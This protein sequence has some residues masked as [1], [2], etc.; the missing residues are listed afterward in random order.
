MAR[1]LKI[2]RNTALTATTIA[3]IGALSAL[4]QTRLY[5]V[6]YEKLFLLPPKTKPIKILHIADFHYVAYRKLETKF[7]ATLDQLHPDLV[8]STGDL[9]GGHNAWP[10]LRKV[11]KP[12]LNYPGAFVFGSNDYY[13]PKPRPWYRYLY[14]HSGVD[15]LANSEVKKPDLPYLEMQTYFTQ[16]GWLNLNNTTAELCINDLTFSLIGVDDHHIG[17]AK[18]PTL[19]SQDMHHNFRLGVTHAP[20]QSILNSFADYQCNLVLGGHTHGGQ[21]CLPFYGA[22]ITNCDLPRQYASG[23][24]EW[25]SPARN[26]TIVNVSAGLGT[27]PYSPIRFACRPEV[28]LLEL[29]PQN[30]TSNTPNE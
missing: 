26:K 19:V 13:A 4:A 30:R 18:M 7:I 17:L 8:V 3:S 28:T 15:F 20:Y 22:L 9:L 10:A 23:I 1:G 2:I 21:V 11:I 29:H 27:S 12:L 14:R 16:A 6:R 24:F 5:H 25:H